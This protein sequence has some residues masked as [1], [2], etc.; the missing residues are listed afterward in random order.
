MKKES[1]MTSLSSTFNNKQ[2][3][4]YLLIA[5]F[6][7]ATL[8]YFGSFIMSGVLAFL[9][10][11]GI[12]LAPRD[13]CKYIFQDALVQQIRDV[14]IKVGQGNL[15]VRI[16]NI[17]E[18]H[19]LHAMAWDINNMLDQTEQLIRDIKASVSAANKGNYERILFKHGYK[20]DFYAVCDGINSAVR[21][22]ALANKGE[23]K[24]DMTNAF[25]KTSGGIA[26]GLDS[27]QNDILKN[28][29]YSQSIHNAASNA[30][31]KVEDSQKS[32][33]GIIENIAQLLSLIETSNQSINS[34]NERT[35]QINTIAGL[36]E[37][38]ANQTNLLALNAAIEAARAGEHGRGFAVVADEVRKL[39]ERTQKATQEI[40]L[41]LHSLQQEA[42][43]VLTG[44]EHMNKIASISQESV[45]NFEDVINDFSQTV[46]DTA[47]KSKLI[48]D[49][50]FTTLIKVEHI[51]I[52]HTA[53]SAIFNENPEKAKGFTKHTD[54][55]LGKWYYEGKG[56][57]LF[58]TTE[59]YKK[60]ALPHEIVHTNIMETT[61][62]A[63]DASCYKPENYDRIVSKM[64][65][66]EENSS[67]LFQYLDEMI[68]QANPQVAI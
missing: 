27:I 48:N 53:Y 3:L 36:I 42:N 68:A 2:T 46:N 4:Y 33:T 54:C 67:L 11:F 47:M 45:S 50:L 20:G 22:I 62:C 32:V 9:A 66:M 8:A 30:S 31:K 38:I 18:T 23:R 39:A 34:L 52:K 58:S 15:S 10:L 17:D 55:R 28:T 43:D 57:E 56:K 29:S 19:I 14:L 5:L 6:G 51:I 25:E 64:A 26:K 16:T 37:D 13:A 1:A 60:L 12:F 61:K 7:A 40:S 44:S 65:Q 59:A 49:S 21:S 41:T 35:N 63:L 24:V